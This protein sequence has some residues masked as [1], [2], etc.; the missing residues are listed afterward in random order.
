MV[1]E[2]DIVLHGREST[3]AEREVGLTIRKEKDPISVLSL[4][5]EK[6][7]KTRASSTN[8]KPTPNDILPSA[9]LYCLEVL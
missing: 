9:R 1:P 5:R 6:E 7:Q 2:G 4:N 8:S 3:A